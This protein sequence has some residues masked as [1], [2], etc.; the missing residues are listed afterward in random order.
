MSLEI[1]VLDNGSSALKGMA[2]NG[3]EVVIESLVVKGFKRSASNGNKADRYSYSVLENDE[4]VSYAVSPYTMNNEELIVTNNIDFQTSTA[5]LIL[6]TH[7]LKELE[8]Q[9]EE[10][11]VVVTLPVSALFDEDENK[12]QK[13]LKDV[14]KNLLRPVTSMDGMTLPVIKDVRVIAE[15]VAA[16]AYAKDVLAITGDTFAIADI[17]GTTTDILVIDKFN[18]II[19]FASP[20]VGTIAF[21]SK[22]AD[23]VSKQCSLP[24]TLP[25]HIAKKAFESRSY[26]GLDLNK[27]VER[28]LDQFKTEV[29]KEVLSLIGD[30]SFVDALIYSGG[31]AAMIGN[32][33]GP[34]EFR[35]N[36][37]QKDNANGIFNIVS[38]QQP[39]NLTK[40]MS[41]NLEKA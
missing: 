34:K 2:L 16:L 26:N 27:T 28:Y 25:P 11:S 18:Q 23:E 14:E 32:D 37:P 7:A 13:L 41:D 19:K 17:G 29:R 10:V 15:G 40:D 35:T 30:Y 20:N 31:G 1:V 39:K 9:Q 4:L 22:F 3:K 5:N 12:A 6:V 21:M 36:N 8:I 38:E 33:L 24:Q